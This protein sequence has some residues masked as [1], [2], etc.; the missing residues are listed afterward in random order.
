MYYILYLASTLPHFFSA[1][2][3]EMAVFPLESPVIGRKII[4]LVTSRTR[5]YTSR[6]RIS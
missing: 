1:L 2:F 6:R 4:A 5:P 3:Q